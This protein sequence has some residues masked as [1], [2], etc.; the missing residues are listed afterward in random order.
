MAD[1]IEKAWA[2]RSKGSVTWGMDRAAVGYNRRTVYK[3]GTSVMYGSTNKQDF[4]NLEG[5]EDHDMNALFFRFNVF[6]LGYAPHR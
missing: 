3:D 6:F 4:Q 2:S 1:A 5:Y